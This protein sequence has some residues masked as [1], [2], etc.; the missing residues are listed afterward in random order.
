MNRKP[1]KPL[2]AALILVTGLRS[3]GATQD[4]GISTKSRGIVEKIR[5]L[6]GQLTPKVIVYHKAGNSRKIETEIVSF[7]A[8]RDK[9][10]KN[11]TKTV[12][13]DRADLEKERAK[14]EK[15]LEKLYA[16]IARTEKKGFQKAI[17]DANAKYD[18]E[19]NRL[20]AFKKTIEEY[21]SLLNKWK[22]FA[23]PGNIGMPEGAVK[24]LPVFS[25]G[26]AAGYFMHYVGKG[27]D[28]LMT[29]KGTMTMRMLDPKSKKVRDNKI[30]FDFHE[31]TVM[32]VI[33]PSLEPLKQPVQLT[34]RGFGD[35]YKQFI[36]V[37]KFT[38][39]SV[40]VRGGYR[41]PVDMPDA[42]AIS[43]PVN[44][45]I[46]IGIPEANGDVNEAEL[47]LKVIEGGRL[48]RTTYAYDESHTLGGIV[49]SATIRG[50][51]GPGEIEIKPKGT[52]DRF[53]VR[54]S[55][56]SPVRNGYN[57]EYYPELQEFDRQRASITL[58]VVPPRR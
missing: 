26:P 41:D 44:F 6:D 17:D 51:W 47:V 32:G 30:L 7:L 45:K 55:P 42:A 56:A 36:V 19:R 38:P 43:K 13:S 20:Q 21:D 22:S 50:H 46:Q 34:L 14:A 39:N 23:Q 9:L 31:I 11:L 24:E 8:K 1:V 52:K 15:N 54:K 33:P 3:L 40:T 25:E 53:T 37:Y 27:F 5:Q 29:Q 10:V 48:K 35:F 16:R 2:F 49:K 18:A 12:E 58:T 57:F 4:T 28:V